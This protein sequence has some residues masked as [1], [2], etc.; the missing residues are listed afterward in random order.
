MNLRICAIGAALFSLSASA[1][2]INPPSDLRVIVSASY[3]AP[4]EIL[5]GFNNNEVQAGFDF[6]VTVDGVSLGPSG[7]HDSL[8]CVRSS[9]NANDCNG[10]RDNHIDPGSGA[11]LAQ[12]YGEAAAIDFFGPALGLPNAIS[13]HQNYYLWGP[14]DYTGATMLILDEDNED[15]RKFFQSVTDLGPVE[16]SPWAQPYEQRLRLYFCRGISQPLPAVWPRL[17]KWL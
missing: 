16:T 10:L 1:L 14:R 9:A 12:N 5:L 17:K 7:V 6:E 13:G 11:I 4:P 3:V 15:E 8:H 2:A